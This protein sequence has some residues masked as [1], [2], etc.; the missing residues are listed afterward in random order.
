MTDSEAKSGFFFHI[1]TFVREHYPGMD[2]CSLIEAIRDQ[3][4]GIGRSI[5]AFYLDAY[6]R[7]NGFD[8]LFFNR[9]GC[10]ASGAI[11]FYIRVLSPQRGRIIRSA[12]EV[13]NF[14][15]PELSRVNQLELTP[16]ALSVEP[17]SIESGTDPKRSR[18]DLLDQAYYAERELQ[19]QSN[20]Y[21][22]RSPIGV[23]D[24]YADQ[25]PEDF[26]KD[27]IS[28]RTKS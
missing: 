3:P 7:N 5:S 8:G 9:L 18:F 14:F 25:F 19:L 20:R 17:A 15:E 10:L 6:V 11:E 13:C 4:A 22:S 2:L 23:I 16:Y 1:S 12:V 27:L 26:P 21:K 28:K 24:W